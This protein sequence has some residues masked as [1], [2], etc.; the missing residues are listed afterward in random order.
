MSLEIYDRWGNL[1]YEEKGDQAS[2]DGRDNQRKI[3]QQ[4]V[5][6]YRLLYIDSLGEEFELFGNVSVLGIE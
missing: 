4:G 6:F 5:Y 3:V 2:W 1:I